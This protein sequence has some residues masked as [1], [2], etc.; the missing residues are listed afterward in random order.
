MTSVTEVRPLALLEAMASGLPVV[1]VAAHGLTDTV[2]PGADGLLTRHDAGEFAGSVRRLLADD[3]VRREMGRH[4]RQTAQM[5]S[6]S[7]TTRRLVA[8]YERA[9]EERSARAA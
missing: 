2:T 7:H 9:R 8:I 6:I 3:A 5:Y 1:A 4:A